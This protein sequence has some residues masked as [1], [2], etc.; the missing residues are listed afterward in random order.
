MNVIRRITSK[1]S[2]SDELSELHID[3]SHNVI[4]IYRINFLHTRQYSNDYPYPPILLYEYP[5]SM[6]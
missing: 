1:H 5:Q 6:F 4:S 3:I 2:D